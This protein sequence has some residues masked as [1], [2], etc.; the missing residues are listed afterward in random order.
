MLF[1]FQKKSYSLYMNMDDEN[2][3]KLNN[4]HTEDKF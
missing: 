2:F 4:Q 3:K 1:N